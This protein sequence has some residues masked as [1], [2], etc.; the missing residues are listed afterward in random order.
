MK[1]LG[2]AFCSH[3]TLYNY[4][5]YLKKKSPKEVV[6]SSE[7]AQAIMLISYKRAMYDFK[8]IELNL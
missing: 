8:T 5:K 3:Y 2:V 6:Q 4:F 1:S 7:Q